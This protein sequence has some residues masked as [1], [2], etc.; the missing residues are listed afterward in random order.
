M[1]D[2]GAGAATGTRILVGDMSFRV[3]GQVNN[4]TML[5]GIPILYTSLHDAQAL[6]LGGRPL[7]TA[8]VT[9]R[10]VIRPARG[11]RIT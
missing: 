9:D 10:R 8:V 3:V 7:V 4:R 5:A 6:A 2:T 11:E 1:A